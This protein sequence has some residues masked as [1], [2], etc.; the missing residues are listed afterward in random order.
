M[1][2]DSFHVRS[3][4]STHSDRWRQRHGRCGSGYTES[5]P[6]NEDRSKAYGLEHDGLMIVRHRIMLADRQ[7]LT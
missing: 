3:C 2:A 1:H 7:T 5:G 4:S 6:D